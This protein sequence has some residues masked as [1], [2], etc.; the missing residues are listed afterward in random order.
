MLKLNACGGNTDHNKTQQST[1]DQSSS[2]FV[3]I[4]GLEVN[5]ALDVLLS[6]DLVII[7]RSLSLL[8]NVL[9]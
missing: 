1:P 2:A 8:T 9:I 7:E 5:V 3:V 4:V 6:V